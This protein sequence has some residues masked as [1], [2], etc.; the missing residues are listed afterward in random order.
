M[1]FRCCCRGITGSHFALKRKAPTVSN[2]RCWLHFDHGDRKRHPILLLVDRHG[3]ADHDAFEL[4]FSM[5][6]KVTAPSNHQHLRSQHLHTRTATSAPTDGDDMDDRFLQQIEETIENVVRQ[7]DQTYN[8]N[9]IQKD[10][11]TAKKIFI[12]NVPPSEREVINIV[13]Y[14]HDRIRRMKRQDICRRCWYPKLRYCI[15]A[16]LQPMALPRYIQQIFI[17]THYR[18]I[19]MMID[20]MK[21]LLCAYPNLCQLVVGGISEQYQTSMQNMTALIQGKGKN[22]HNTCSINNTKTLV[23]FPSSD[24][25]TFPTYYQLQEQQMRQFQSIDGHSNNISWQTDQ[26]PLYNIIVI[27]ATWEQARRLYQRHI[28]QLHTTSSTAEQSLVHIQ[29]SETSLQTLN[30]HH[31]RDGTQPKGS[32]KMM[33][34]QLRPHPIS[35]REIATAH[36]VQLLLR[37]MIT[38]TIEGQ[39]DTHESKQLSIQLRDQQQLMFDQYQQ[40]AMDTA[41]KVKNWGK[42][43]M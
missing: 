1:V 36:A 31:G 24:A 32:I 13:R 22:N 23:L 15:C 35:V 42:K 8:I 21:I 12:S 10:E 27:D 25:V 40:T 43:T 38:T 20:T 26:L 19:G 17:L 4:S 33:G 6:P 9:I 34:Q 28:V 3:S 11:T 2:K 14:L 37:D 39:S 16:T 29:L 7:Y 18:E 41:L 5:T 30:K